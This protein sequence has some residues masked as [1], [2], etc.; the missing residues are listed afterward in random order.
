M[1]RRRTLRATALVPALVLVTALAGCAR[2]TTASS[3]G[4]GLALTNPDKLTTCTHSGYPPF[5]FRENGELVGFDVELVDAIAEDLGLEQQLV[6]T[7]F[8]SIQSGV[9]LNSNQCDVAAAAMSITPVRDENFDFSEP[10]FEVTQALLT[11]RG[12]GLKQLADLRGRTV[13]VQLATTGEKFVRKNAGANGYRVVQFENLP[14]LIK[15]VETGR[16]D[17]AIN[18][19]SVLAHYT[20]N[21]AGLEI[22]NEFET[23][24]E[25]GIGVATGDDAL[26]KKINESLRRIKESG[27][28][29]EI[30][31]K[32]FGGR[33]E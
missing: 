26:L 29:D 30:Y 1:A 4:E 9:A 13:G 20:E 17:V 27:R 31:R 22:T 12:A 21:N 3:S 19:N 33:P 15:A 14:L 24:D 16:V 10:Y 23:G 5:Q 32:W 2:S 25:Y 11:P 7:P 8:S 28:Y 18:D 6:A